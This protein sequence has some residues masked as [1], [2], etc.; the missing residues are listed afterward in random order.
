MFEDTE[1]WIPLAECVDR[2]FYLIYARNFYY[3]VFSKEKNGF[4]GIRT[5]FGQR[6]LFTEYHWDTGEPHGTAKPFEA[7]NVDLP[8]NIELDEFNEEL[9]EYLDTMQN[10]VKEISEFVK[11]TTENLKKKLG[12]K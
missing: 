3:G 1:N 5:K 4:I 6:Y 10:T 11:T 7:L 2:K 9:F 8:E 12:V